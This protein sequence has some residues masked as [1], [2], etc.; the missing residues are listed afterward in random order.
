MTRLSLRIA[1]FSIL[2]LALA[3]PCFALNVVNTSWTVQCIFSP[4]CSVTVTDY[5]ADFAVP[6]GSGNGRL[7]SRVFQSQ[8][9]RWVYEYRINMS[10]VAGFTY[11][12]YADYLAI[13]S[14]GT[15]QPYD[16]NSDGVATD[17]VFNITSGGCS[18]CTKAVTAAFP[19]SPNW[20]Y[21][22]VGGLVYSGSYPGGGESSYFFGQVSNAAPVLRTLY[23]HLDTG[24]V[25]VQGYAPPV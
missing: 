24:W 25:A 22:H 15:F 9:G 23:V 4:S 19:V 6:G 20:T 2:T 18:G 10:Q 7:Q 16:F 11:P 8:D 21:W 3:A 12:P 13:S 14:W 5:A 1:L 17:H